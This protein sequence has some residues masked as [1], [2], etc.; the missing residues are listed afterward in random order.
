MNGLSL[1]TAINVK[2]QKKTRKKRIR[3]MK[4]EMNGIC[5]RLFFAS[6][7]ADYSAEHRNDNVKWA[8]ICLYRLFAC[9]CS[10]CIQF[11]FPTSTFICIINQKFQHDIS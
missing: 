1:T 7:Y 4:I 6:Y 5:S 10:F 9:E 11:F 2:Q 8:G 3:Q